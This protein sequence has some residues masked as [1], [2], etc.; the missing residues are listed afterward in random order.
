MKMGKCDLCDSD[1]FMLCDC[2]SPDVELG[3]KLDKIIELLQKLD[4]SINRLK[5]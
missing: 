2:R 3:K 5:E 4:N 1:E